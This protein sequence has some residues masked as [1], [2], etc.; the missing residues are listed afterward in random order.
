MAGNRRSMAEF[1]NLAKPGGPTVT[2]GL[3][4]ELPIETLVPRPGQSRRTIDPAE[5]VQMAA[6]LTGNCSSVCP[7]RGNSN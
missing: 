7:G 3:K 4:R 6:T 1:L 2:D 5:L